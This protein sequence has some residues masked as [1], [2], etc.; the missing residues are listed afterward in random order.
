M[1]LFLIFWWFCSPRRATRQFGLTGAGRDHL[2][3]CVVSPHPCALRVGLGISPAQPQFLPPQGTF[4]SSPAKR[5]ANGS[6]FSRQ[7]KVEHNPLRG[8]GYRLLLPPTLCGPKSGCFSHLPHCRSVWKMHLPQGSTRAFPAPAI[9]G[10]VCGALLL[11][12]PAFPHPMSAAVWFGDQPSSS[13]RTLH[14]PSPQPT[15]CESS[16][17]GPRTLPCLSCAAP[18][19]RKEK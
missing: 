12:L 7:N 6:H 4:L 15:C 2:M 18:P 14:S 16:P 10:R 5:K 17:Q 13:G 1:G 19:A 3:Y 8:G 9:P 11:L